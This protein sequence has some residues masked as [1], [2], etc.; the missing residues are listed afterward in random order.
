MARTNTAE[1]AKLLYEAGEEYTDF[2]QL[3]DSGDQ[4]KYESGASM[5]SGRSGYEPD[6]RPNGLITGGEVTPADSNDSVDVAAL[7][8]YLAGVE[9]SVA[10]GS[11]SVSRPSTDVAKISSITVDSTGS[12]VEVTGTDG[13]DQTFSESRGA[14][15]GP[16]WIPTDSIE[17]AQVRMTTSASAKFSK[18][19]IKQVVGKHRERWD[20]PVWD[21][22]MFDATVE[23]ISALPTIHSDDS[24]STTKTKAV[25]AAYY[26][27]TFTEQPYCS[28]FQAPEKSHS[29]NST[30][31]YGTT[32]ASHSSSLGQGSFTTRLKDGI[33]DNLVAMKDEEIWFKFF[34]DRNKSPYLACQGKLGVSRSYPAGDHIQ[35]ECTISAIEPAEGVSS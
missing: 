17:I 19:Q 2:T 5:W 7:T 16:P 30:Q 18:D 6:V 21:E 35:A 26:E 8:A 31:V 11:V 4:T 13:S 20:S 24:G 33:T 14:E 34:P 15:G 12:L 27:P 22:H 10:S 23:F 1:N 3:T 28:D 32:L 29:V 9:D 25:W